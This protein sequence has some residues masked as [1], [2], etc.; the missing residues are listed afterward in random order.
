MKEYKVLTQKDKWF[1]GKFDPIKLEGALN[2]YAQQGWELVTC[3]TA[4]VPGFGTARQEFVAILVR[5]I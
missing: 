2:S 4:D 5:N 3:A 1:S